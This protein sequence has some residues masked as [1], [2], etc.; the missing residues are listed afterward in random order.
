MPK[1]SEITKS[2]TAE[3]AAIDKDNPILYYFYRPLS[4][5]PTKLFIKLGISDHETVLI[6]FLI[7]LIAMFLFISGNYWWMLAGAIV[8]NI[9]FMCD[10]MDGNLARYN[11]T[12]SR[13]GEWLDKVNDYF[14]WGLFPIAIG[15]GLRE[16]GWPIFIGATWSIALLLTYVSTEAFRACY[17]IIPRSFH[18]PKHKGLYN[19]IYKSG[20]AIARMEVPMII[21][22]AVFGVLQWYLCF[23]ALLAI[24][25]Y[26]MVMVRTIRGADKS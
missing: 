13:Y 23:Y 26:G 11:K 24:G 4:F 7:N 1:I 5:Y 18:L 19:L 2:Y 25:T 16:L 8:A 17:G 21:V 12:A 3:K 6:G 15:I 22:F 20:I 9:G 10:V 14:A